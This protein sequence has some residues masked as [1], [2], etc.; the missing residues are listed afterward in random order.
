MI[1]ESVNFSGYAS[2]NDFDWNWISGKFRSGRSK[3]LVSLR[4]CSSLEEFRVA[5]STFHARLQT[6]VG[7]LSS[8]L[9]RLSYRFELRE[10]SAFLSFIRKRHR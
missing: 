4:E 8:D 5:R 3:F 10:G 7:A 1:G 2:S 9:P 6:R